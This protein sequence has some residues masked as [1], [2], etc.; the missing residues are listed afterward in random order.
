M[1]ASSHRKSAPPYRLRPTTSSPERLG[2]K[3]GPL[4][5]QQ[6]G[7]LS[8]IVVSS[9][10]IAEEMIKTHDVNFAQRPSLLATSF[11]ESA[12]FI[13]VPYRNYWRQL[14]RICTQELLNA[15]RIQS[16]NR[17]GQKS[18]KIFS[19]TYG[20]T[21]KAAFGKKCKDQEDFIAVVKEGM[22]ISG[23]FSVSEENGDLAVPLENRNIKAIML[24]IFVAG[25]DTS[26]IAL[27]WAML[28]MLKNL[29]VM[30]KAQAETLRL[31]P[32]VPF[33]L[34]RES[35]ERCAI[36]GYDVPAKTKVIVIAWAIG[37]DPRYWTKA[38]QFYPERFTDS[39]VD[40]K[41]TNFEFIPFSAGRRMCPGISFALADIELRYRSISIGNFLA[42]PPM[43]I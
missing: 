39:S 21:A 8:D 6:L 25:S 4:M 28:E 10:E 18:E 37:R 20:I 1:E 17:L 13:F 35:R 14:R 42:G 40:V 2:E 23:G 9:P 16:S 26:S 24:D 31:H 41:G 7:E 19:L 30:E 29:K 36:N 32:P 11:Y 43:K 22:K 3:Y 27:E 38:E 15:R 12:N 5:H 34:P 33:L